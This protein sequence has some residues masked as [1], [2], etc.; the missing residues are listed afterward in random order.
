MTWDW[1][2]DAVVRCRAIEAVVD[3]G[4]GDL[5]SGGIEAVSDGG[6]LHG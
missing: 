3:E 5:H 6:Y 4:C 2:E 1:D